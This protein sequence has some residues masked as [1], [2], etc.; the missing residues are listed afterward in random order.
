MPAQGASVE[1]LHRIGGRRLR[2]HGRT[3]TRSGAD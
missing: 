3:I 2:W 1:E